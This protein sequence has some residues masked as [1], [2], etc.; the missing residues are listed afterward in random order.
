LNVRIATPAFAPDMNDGRGGYCCG[1]CGS[2]D[3]WF[4]AGD[5][6]GCANCGTYVTRFWANVMAEL[7]L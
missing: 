7:E 4:E 6:Y 3:D 2:A 1:Y 5:D